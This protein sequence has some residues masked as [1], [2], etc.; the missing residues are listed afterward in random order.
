MATELER[1]IERAV[2]SQLISLHGI[3]AFQREHAGQG[4][5]INTAEDLAKE[6]VSAGRLTKF[7]VSAIYQGKTAGLV[8]GNYIVLDKIG[9]G[10]LGNVFSAKHCQTGKTV[11]LKV[12]STAAMKSPSGVRRF[13]QVVSILRQLKHPYIVGFCEAGEID[14]LPYLTMQ[15]ITGE[16]L[17]AH[18]KTH[19]P[20]GLADAVE[21][22][23]QV[24]E[25]LEC[26]HSA[27]VIHRGIQPSNLMLD[28]SGQVSIIGFG[29]AHLEKS[30]E[31][32]VMHP[33]KLE[34]LMVANLEF[35]AP[36]LLEDPRLPTPQSDIYALGCT[37]FRLLTGKPPYVGDSVPDTL[38]QHARSP[39]PKLRAP[40]PD[41]SV[42]LEEILCRM[43]AKNP[44]DRYQSASEVR[45]ALLNLGIAS[46]DP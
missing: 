16:N 36:E 17:L 37:M 24:A 30:T 20:V 34:M 5:S 31:S 1:F 15:L 13:Q 41:A 9:G 3:T 40:R 38:L 14:S 2:E 33:V 4:N 10:A 23:V 42:E 28:K 35:I 18:I 21:Y 29:M 43:M 45:K 11:A 8:F 12:I 46:R 44:P 32:I 26:A 39:I 25:G 27:G 7:Q 6:L 19:G 22:T